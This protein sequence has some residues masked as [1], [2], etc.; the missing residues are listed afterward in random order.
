[1]GLLI[2]DRLVVHQLSHV[3]LRVK[4]MATDW[5]DSTKFVV[6]LTDGRYVVDVRV[7]WAGRS[8]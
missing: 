5:D 1:M 4:W 8:A 2:F 6:R 3:G 7:P